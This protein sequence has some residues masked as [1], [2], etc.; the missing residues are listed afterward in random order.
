MSG[1]QLPVPVAVI[2]KRTFAIVTSIGT[3]SGMQI[4]SPSLIVLPVPGLMSPAT[5]EA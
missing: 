3:T 5:W 1:Y 2:S 4:T